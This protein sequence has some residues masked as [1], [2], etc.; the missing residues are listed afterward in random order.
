[1][2]AAQ[3]LFIRELAQAVKAHGNTIGFDLGNELNTCWRA[4]PSVGDHW[5]TKMFGLIDS[6]FPEH[7]NVNGVDED[8]WFGSTTF[9]QEALISKQPMSVMHCYPYWS[10]ALKYGGAMDPPSTRLLA[11]M[12][13]LIRSYAGTQNKPVLGGTIQHLH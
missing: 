2:W 1:M 3:E 10:G 7:P 9:S 5:M 12:A 11:A 6:V 8:P 4:P 13:A